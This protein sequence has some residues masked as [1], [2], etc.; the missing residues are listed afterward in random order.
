MTV[1]D[2]RLDAAP[3]SFSSGEIIFVKTTNRHF[4]VLGTCVYCLAVAPLSC[5]DVNELGKLECLPAK[6]A[7]IIHSPNRDR[8]GNRWLPPIN[9]ESGVLPN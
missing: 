1:S 5:C 8:Q 9:F 2:R 6:C 4:N 7:C 3:S